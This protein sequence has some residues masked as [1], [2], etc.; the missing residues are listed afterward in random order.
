MRLAQ[1]FLEQEEIIEKQAAII[2]GLLYE[3]MQFRALTE[4]EEACLGIHKDKEKQEG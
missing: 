4:E 3:I 1:V 2:R